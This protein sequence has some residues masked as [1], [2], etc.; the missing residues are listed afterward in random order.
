M[1]LIAAVVIDQSRNATWVPP[2]L[3]SASIPPAFI[4][5]LTGSGAGVISANSPTTNV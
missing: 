1:N 2:R 3:T 5:A 4:C